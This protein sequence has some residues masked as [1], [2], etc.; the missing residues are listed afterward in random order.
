LKKQ[1]ILS[2]SIFIAGLC[3]IIYELLISATATYF[4]GDGVRQFSILIGVYL[5]S[6]GI[7]AYFSKFFKHKPIH[8]F[9][10]IEFILGFIGGISVPTLYFAFVYIDPASLQL[11]CLF[12]M[13]VIGLLT[14]MEVPLLT[15][16]NDDKNFEDNLSNVLSVD[17]LGGLIATII[18]PFVLLPF[19]G[20]FYSSILFGIINLFLGFFMYFTLNHERSKKTI[21]FGV[22]L[23]IILIVFGIF[24]SQ[25]LKIWEEKIYKSPII[26]NIQSPYQKIVITKN[27][28]NVKLF[29]NRTIQFSSSDEHRYHEMLVHVPLSFLK[30][31]KNILVLGGGE[32]LATREILKHENI[33]QIDVVDIDP[34]MFE[35]AKNNFQI[36]KINENAANNPK[37]NLINDDAFVYLKN[38]FKLYDLIIADLPDPSN[39]SIAKLYSKQF[40]KLA[41]RSLKKDGIFITQAG[42]INFSNLAF[43]CIY[44]TLGNVFDHKNP[45]YVNIPSFGQWGFIMA[46]NLPFSQEKT[47]V[48]PKNLKYL[49]SF[50]LKSAFII[51]KDIEFKE[52]KINSI[53][54]PV[55]LNYFLDEW[56]KNAVEFTTN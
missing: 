48:L 2:I 46:S 20:L 54:Q 52:T 22:F 37:V 19:I 16:V 23:L 17:Y 42:E 15:F 13:F 18:F 55:L 49:D 1:I 14:G 33:L 3:S 53:D 8:F 9:I 27:Q 35:L 38:N 32:N 31:A 39:N 29:L 21:F 24:T 5:F 12:M 10:K 34:E 51:P 44:N 25:L 11:L 7:G 41:Q 28:E 30:N 45:Y 43:N 56:Q 26:T 50:Q 6:M 36:K 47:Y 40:F 4:L